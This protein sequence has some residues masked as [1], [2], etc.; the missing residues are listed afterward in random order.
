[1]LVLNHCDAAKLES[2]VN[3]L[4]RMHPDLAVQFVRSGSTYVQR[5]RTDASVEVAS[6]TIQE[7]EDS[8][9]EIAAI[10]AKWHGGLDYESGMM[11]R[12]GMIE[13]H[14]DGKIRLFLTVHH[15]VIDGVSWRILLQD[16]Y[17]L[18]HG[19]ELPSVQSPFKKWQA[20]ITDYA[21]KEETVRH[22]AYWTEVLKRTDAFQLPVDHCADNRS[23]TESAELVATLQ[24][25]DSQ[26]LLHQCSHAY[27]TEINDLL[28]TAWS[29]M[30]SAW[31][32]QETVAFRLEGHGREHCVSD[33][34][35]T[36]SIGW[37][38]SMFPVCIQVSE[39][40]LGKTIKSVKEQ[41]RRIP[42]HGISYGALRYCHSSEQVRTSL[43]ASEPQVLF[44]TI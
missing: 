3:C 28:L 11:L 29:L 12:V 32:E 15:L 14:P 1:M 44:L 2:A 39:S 38:T 35:L 20:A 33:M 5:Y 30:L 9:P 24:A 7:T 41:L 25:S 43:T 21:S 19:A 42:D 22:V 16:L 17:H 37:F 10:C 31:S 4:I 27:H 23:C 40:S 26:R 36:R 6:Y 18:Y 8:D 34:D 13:G